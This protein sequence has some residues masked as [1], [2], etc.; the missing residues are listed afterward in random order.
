MKHFCLIFFLFI[1]I[2]PSFANKLTHKDLGFVSPLHIPL[3]LSGN[4]GEIRANH[5]HSGLDIKTEHRTG[6][7]VYA[8]NNGYVSRIRVTAG[9]GYMLDIAYPYGVSS[10]YRHLNGFVD[11]LMSIVKKI[12]YKK[13]SWEIDYQL[14][15]NVYPVKAD[16]QVAWSGNTGFSA[17]PHLHLDMYRTASKEYIDPLPL[18]KQYVPDHQRP[19]AE[20]LQI[21]P[22]EG[23]GVVNGTDRP[24]IF[25]F[26]NSITAWGKIGIT[27]KAH[28][29]MDGTWYCL[30]VRYITLYLDGKKVFF[31]NIGQYAPSETRMVNSCTYNGFIKSY[32]DPGNT[33]RMMQA[34]NND[35][36]IITIN[37]ER[38][39]HFH[40]VL[41]DVFGNTSNYHFTI[42]GKRQSIAPAKP[43]TPYMLAWNK[44]NYLQ[45]PGM[46]LIVPF[47][48]LCDNVYLN[49]KVIHSTGIAYK[50]QLSYPPIPLNGTCELKIGL[51]K[52]P[53]PNTQKYY[54]AK[55]VGNALLP[56]ADSKFENGY[57]IAKIKELNTYTVAVDEMPPHIIPL[58]QRS[59]N[60]GKLMFSISDGGS[61]IK[62]YCGYI[63]GQYAIFDRTVKNSII[64]CTVDGE[65]VQRHKTHTC[66]MIVTDWCGNIATYTKAFKW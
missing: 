30:G 4:F 10:T 43:H 44:T 55:L 28:D 1:N 8:M 61:G 2:C 22:V 40:Y 37:Q 25:A 26:G 57:V 18:L 19:L 42:R 31:D 6:L 20:R 64:T 48:M 58:N 12:Q 63:D 41:K 9:S 29:Y 7:P 60:N 3:I 35:R 13:K 24:H 47:G 53:T 52:R 33:L 56:V 66:K 46:T 5:F 54:I 11:R 39:Y 32:N 59:W 15:P 23:Q 50:Y 17:G 16:E 49:F 27:L 51:R 62:C 21:V 65:K 36:G 45:E 14:P 38:D 34:F